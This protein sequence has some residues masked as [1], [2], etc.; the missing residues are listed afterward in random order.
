MS[1]NDIRLIV[2]TMSKVFSPS[3]G[4]L[5]ICPN[6]KPLM[7]SRTNAYWAKCGFLGMTE[8]LIDIT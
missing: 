5:T 8:G 1:L 2:R 6:E 3:F 4:S 7:I